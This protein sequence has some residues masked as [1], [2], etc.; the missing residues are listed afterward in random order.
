MA[1]E[2]IAT[3]RSIDLSN[4]AI[5]GAVVSVAAMLERNT[6]ITSLNLGCST[7]GPDGAKALASMLGKNST[8]LSLRLAE[9]K[10]LSDGARAIAAALERNA[11]LTA[12]DLSFNGIGAE[13]VEALAKALEVNPTLT[14]LDI[15]WNAV[16]GECT[17]SI[18]AA[19]Q[20]NRSLRSQF[21]TAFASGDVQAVAAMLATGVDATAEA[22]LEKLPHEPRAEHLECAWL[23]VTSRFGP[24]FLLKETEKGPAMQ[25]LLERMAPLE[26][27]SQQGMAEAIA[28]M[29]PKTRYFVEMMHPVAKKRVPDQLQELAAGARQVVLERGALEARLNPRPLAELRSRTDAALQQC[30]LAQFAAMAQDLDRA[31]EELDVATRTRLRAALHA[32]LLEERPKMGACLA[33]LGGELSCL[34]QWPWPPRARRSTLCWPRSWPWR[35][36]RRKWRAFTR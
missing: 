6:T 22:L 11:T 15:S 8:L 10:I 34:A 16:S 19:L 23:L 5:G 20:R 28:Q 4:N 18:D 2:R 29:L 25:A 32:L 31:E 35:I 26:S 14:T 33:A 17:L 3:L 12:L 9:N 13:G 30:Q 7:L 27:L 21:Q 36:W 1:L 24:G